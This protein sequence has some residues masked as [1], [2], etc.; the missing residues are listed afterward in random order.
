MHMPPPQHPSTHG[1]KPTVQKERGCQAGSTEMRSTTANKSQK[2]NN[3]KGKKNENGKCNTK[4][5]GIIPAP[6]DALARAST[7]S[8]SCRG[9]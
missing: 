6:H 4:E 9:W 7:P 2:A 1:T 5:T 8:S 3:N